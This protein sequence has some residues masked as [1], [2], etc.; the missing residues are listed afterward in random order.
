MTLT[1]TGL[2]YVTDKLY[3][4][5]WDAHEYGPNVRKGRARAGMEDSEPPAGRSHGP[6]AAGNGAAKP[7]V[8]L[9]GS[10]ME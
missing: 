9:S 3:K 6:Q 8:H 4:S 10:S 2:E 1:Y 7:Q 5:V